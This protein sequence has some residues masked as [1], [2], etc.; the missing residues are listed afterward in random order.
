MPNITIIQVGTG[1]RAQIPDTFTELSSQLISSCWNFNPNDRPSF[2]QIYDEIENNDFKLIEMD[3][4]ET[5][6]VKKM[7]KNHK[8]KIPNY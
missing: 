5:D 2:E 4:T 8:M 1:Q 6:E 7:I 3:E